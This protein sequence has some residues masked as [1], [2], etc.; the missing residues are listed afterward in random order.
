MAARKR[1][2]KDMAAATDPMEKAVQNGRQL[3]LKVSANSVY[4]FTGATVGQLPCIAIA[5]SVT[6]YGRNLLY[7]TR[8]F[9]EST[10]TIA[11]GFA[12]NAEVV[13]GDTDS[14]MVKFGP[15]TVADAMPLA[16]RAA[17]EVSAIFPRPISLEFEKIYYPFLLMNKKRY[18][19][20]LWTN[21][22]KY[23]KL[24]AKGLET[25]R[26]DNCLLVRRLIDTC[27]RKILIEQDVQG[28][29]DYAKNTIADLLQN[30]LDISMLVIS[31]SLGKAADDEG[32][33]AKQAHV[34]LAM[35][36]RRRDPG[37]APNVGDRVAYVIIEKAK[38]AP[39]YEKSEDPVFVLENN[40]PIDTEYY[41]TNQLSNPLTRIFEPIIGNPQTLLSGDHTRTVC[42][43]T[44]TAQA[45]GIM[46][47]AVKKS[48]CMGCKTPIP[49]NSP[50]CANCTGKER[51]I[52]LTKLSEVNVHQE[53]YSKLWTE[54]QRC[55]G[56]YHQDVICSNR[57][58]PI[59][60]KRKKVQIDLQ[61]AQDSLDR[62]KW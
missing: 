42:K 62:F 57:D 1:A 49:E 43:P 5:S 4:G 7:E 52:Y 60:Y 2:K 21:P 39:A 17:K 27:L 32:Y 44:P 48:K 26:R 3:A 40:L 45:G 30:K 50:L 19:G 20:L 14:V 37:S 31:K 59:F 56:S 10:Y 38:G 34:E 8:T 24:D 12:H 22:A 54:C 35:R 16:E 6:A 58:C 15:T 11:N 9:V 55:Q 18:A 51:E 61:A 41:L 33:A 25:V 53:V 29:I 23:D 46:M 47:F 13:Y 36:M 28:A